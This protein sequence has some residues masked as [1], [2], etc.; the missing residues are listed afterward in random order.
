LHDP[1]QSLSGVTSE[2]P[3]PLLTVPQ[4][5][6]LL[7]ISIADFRRLRAARRIPGLV[8]LPNGGLRVLPETVQP[9]GL[10]VAA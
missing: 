7:G 8:R 2:R 4:V 6:D 9:I 3:I 1:N 5:C 10:G